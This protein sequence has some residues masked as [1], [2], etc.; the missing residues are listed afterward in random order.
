MRAAYYRCAVVC[1]SVC[2]LDLTMSCAKADEPIKMPSGLW[3]QVG[4]SMRYDTIRDERNNVLG[5][6]R[7]GPPAVC[8]GGGAPLR[9]GLSSKSLTNCCTVKEIVICG[10]YGCFATCSSV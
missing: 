4:H 5:G 7:L 9:C 10:W 6:T 8:F 1:V 3:T 2:P